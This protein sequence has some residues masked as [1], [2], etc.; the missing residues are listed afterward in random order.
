M[1]GGLFLYLL[2]SYSLPAQDLRDPKFMA[3]A[4]AGFNDIFNMDY[5]RAAVIFVSLEKDYPQH[6]APPLY[7]SSIL[8]LK[9]ML[10]RQ[11][12]TLSRFVNPTYFSARTNQSMRPQDRAE[13]FRKLQQSEA[14]SKA[15]LQR[16]SRNKDARYFLATAYGLRSSFAITIDHRIRE[17]FSYG[18]KAYSYSRQLTQEDPKYYDAYLTIGIYEYIAGS[19]PWYMRWMVYIIG[20]HGSKQEGIALLQLAA[21]K[22][23]YVEDQARLVLMVLEVREHRYADALTIARD[24][25]NRFPRSYLLSINQA[26]ILRLAGRKEEAASLLLQIEKRVEMGE[27]NYDKLSLPSFRF[28][29][30]VELMNMGKLELAQERFQRSIDDRKA[31]V[32]EKALSHLRLCQILDWRGQ[33]A[34]AAKECR[35][36]LSLQDIEDSHDQAEKLLRHLR[37]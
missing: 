37:R 20:V 2:L 32:R 25:G 1:F 31:T 28:N 9:E 27:P 19:I 11:D 5:D 36:V 23:Q 29:L 26:Q 16:N 8:W 13:F 6:P 24:L 17:A 15:I 3:R 14:L 33:P 34:E 30:A 22:G 10:R 18:S 12:L 7:L 35:I 21:E 4:E